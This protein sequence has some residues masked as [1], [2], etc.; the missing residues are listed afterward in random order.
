MQA[1]SIWQGLRRHNPGGYYGWR[2]AVRL[3]QGDLR[4]AAGEARPAP[5][6]RWQPL[7]SGD[8]GLDRLWRLAQTTEAWETWRQRRGGRRAVGS[9]E[10]LLEGRLRLGVEDDWTGLAQLD[11]AL[12]NLP[13]GQCRRQR[14]LELALHPDRFGDLFRQEAG[15]H[16]IAVALLQGLAK[17]E[18][19]FTPAVQSA[20]GA[21]GVMQLMPETAAELAGRRLSSTDL[22]QPQRNIALGSLYLARMLRQWQGDVL[23]AVASYNA[24]PGAVADWIQPRLREAPEL[25]VEAIPYPETRLYVKKVLGNAWSYQE[26][27]LPQCS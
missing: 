1:R 18:S 15:R 23:L 19:R 3:G 26:R 4:L 16:G 14:Q 25:W 6:L 12:L 11:Q 17:Q 8:A 5:W 2:A 10:L 24:G 22:E 7:A 27:R 9:E 20:V 21:V 13:A